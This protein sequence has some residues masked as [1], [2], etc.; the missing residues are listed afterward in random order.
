MSAKKKKKISPRNP[1]KS[2]RRT[3]VGGKLFVFALL[4]VFGI[5]SLSVLAYFAPEIGNHLY[6]VESLNRLYPKIDLKANKRNVSL[7][8]K[9]PYYW[10]S[11]NELE[12]HTIG[13]VIV[14]EDWAFFQHGGLDIN[15]IQSA[16]EKTVQNKKRLRGAST[17]TQQV[18]KNVYL[19][20]QRS[21]VRKI[22]ELIITLALERYIPKKKIIEIYLNIAEWGPN[23]YGISS[24]ARYYFNKPAQ[25]LTPRES[26]FLAMLLPNPIKYSA[27]FHQKALTNFGEKRVQDILTKMEKAKFISEE[28]LFNA[29][30]SILP[31]ENETDNQ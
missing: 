17:I 15:Q 27:S 30:L 21:Y 8:K 25:F 28:V 3:S 5:L 24:A 23:I 26:A 1:S 16:L 11:Y 31:F 14:A 18:A 19:S 22:K 2:A 4:G 9:R 10:V 6:N 12:N 20:F 29:Q 7:S 13:A